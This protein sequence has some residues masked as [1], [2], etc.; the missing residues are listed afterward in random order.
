MAARLGIVIVNYRTADLVIACVRSLREATLRP[1][2]V[3]VDNG[4]GDGSAERIAAAIKAEDWSN[5]VWLSG[6]SAVAP[7]LAPPG[8]YQARPTHAAARFSPPQR[9]PPR[10]FAVR[11]VN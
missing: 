9:A 3:L 8:L 4:S 5:W 2:V 10:V 11:E 6:Q 1:G 7:P